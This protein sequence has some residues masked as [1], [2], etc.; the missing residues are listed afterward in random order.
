MDTT[1]VDLLN[2]SPISLFQQGLLDALVKEGLDAWDL[3]TELWKFFGSDKPIRQN[4]K[5]RETPYV[6]KARMIKTQVAYL[7][8]HRKKIKKYINGSAKKAVQ[9]ISNLHNT[10]IPEN[11]MVT[12]FHFRVVQDRLLEVEEASKEKPP[13]FIG[14]RIDVSDKSEKEWLAAFVRAEKAVARINDFYIR[15]KRAR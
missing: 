1:T 6:C 5:P 12:A 14:L 2:G 4:M 9:I 3:Q 13:L 15:G 8:R 7:Y 11:K 10:Y